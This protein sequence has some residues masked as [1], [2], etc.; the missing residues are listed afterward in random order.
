MIKKKFNVSNNNI[1][2]EKYGSSVEKNKSVAGCLNEDIAFPR[3]RLISSEGENLGEFAIQDALNLAK[4]ENLDLVLIS[5]GIKSLPV[6]KIMNYSKKIYEDKKKLKLAKKK[7]VET[8][9]KEIRISIKISNHDLHHKILQGVDF[10]IDCIRVK[11]SLFLKGRERGLKD[12]LGKG[13]M[14]K[15]TDLFHSE[16]QKK[17]EFKRELAYDD[18]SD[19]GSAMYRVFYLKK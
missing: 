11:V 6:V 4:D 8:K 13:L 12:T 9:L 19:S 1:K 14:Q 2:N 17:N 5:S 18:G 16:L 3:V 15:V 7:N 10:L